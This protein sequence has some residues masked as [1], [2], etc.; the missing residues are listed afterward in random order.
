MQSDQAN[1]LREKWGNKPCSHPNFEKEYCLGGDTG[2]YACTTCG[3]SITRD[4]YQ[5]LRAERS[6]EKE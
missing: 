1:K 4:K 2:D 3:E 5:E 6:I